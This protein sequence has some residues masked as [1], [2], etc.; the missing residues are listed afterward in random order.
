[1]SEPKKIDPDALW[2]PGKS[3]LKDLVLHAEIT[4]WT[5]NDYLQGKPSIELESDKGDTILSVNEATKEMFNVEGISTIRVVIEDNNARYT[6]LYELWIK[7]W[8]KLGIWECSQWIE[9]NGSQ[10]TPEKYDWLPLWASLMNRN[11]IEERKS[12][13]K[14]LLNVQK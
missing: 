3:S 6:F 11:L 8:Y 7:P 14:E 1:M 12:W 4:G 2:G 9:S 13:A 10:Y 5:T